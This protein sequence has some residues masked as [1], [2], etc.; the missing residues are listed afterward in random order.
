MFNAQIA[1]EH[2]PSC[3]LDQTQ[4]LVTNARGEPENL[5]EW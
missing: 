4:Q 3:A 5:V 2:W 1:Y